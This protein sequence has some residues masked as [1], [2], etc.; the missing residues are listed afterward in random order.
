MYSRSRV[1]SA[2]SNTHDA[3]GSR[4]MRFALYVHHQ[5]TITPVLNYNN[6]YLNLNHHHHKRYDCIDHTFDEWA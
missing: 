1:R 6:Y 3:Y 4:L 2:L 5:H